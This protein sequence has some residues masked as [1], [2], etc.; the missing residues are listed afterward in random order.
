[1]EQNHQ[2]VFTNTN[3]GDGA[4]LLLWGDKQPVTVVQVH[5][6]F[7][8][9]Q[10]DNVLADGSFQSNPA[11]RTWRFRFRANNK[12]I[13][14]GHR[15]RKNIETDRW[16]SLGFA[17]IEFGTREFYNDLTLVDEGEKDDE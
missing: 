1:M 4:T 2:E 13:V 6:P 7:I 10:E 14:V 9:V 8:V 5:K 15:V 16:I 12:G 11:G 3:A 17:H